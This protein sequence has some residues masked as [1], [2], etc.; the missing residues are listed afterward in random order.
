MINFYIQ[1][2][3]SLYF[4]ANRSVE[5]GF[6]CR[7]NNE[8]KEGGKEKQTDD[9]LFDAEFARIN[10][11]IRKSDLLTEPFERINGQNN[12]KYSLVNQAKANH[13]DTTFC[14]QMLKHLADDAIKARMIKKLFTFFKSEEY[15]TG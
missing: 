6:R 4:C 1:I 5:A 12:S 10:L 9:E 2:L 14:D 13:G 15:E 8:Q 3:D 11:T 7:A